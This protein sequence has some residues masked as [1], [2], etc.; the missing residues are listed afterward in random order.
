ML[1]IVVATD[2]NGAI[3]QDGTIPWRCPEDQKAFAKLTKSGNYP[4]V[5]MGRKTAESLGRALP[6]R[7]NIVVTSKSEAPYPNMEVADS[8]DR[9]IEMATEDL[10]ADYEN[11]IYVIGGARLYAEA[12]ALKCPTL[13]HITMIYTFAKRPDT[14]FPNWDRSQWIMRNHVFFNDPALNLSYSYSTSIFERDL[15][16]V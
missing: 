3:G 13:L 6:H 2:Q 12:M 9:A 7:R 4:T 1:H 10:L 11:D 8:L 5:I 16:K 15:S 14:Y